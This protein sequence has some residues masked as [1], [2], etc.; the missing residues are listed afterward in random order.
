MSRPTNHEAITQTHAKLSTLT[1]LLTA[2]SIT[3]PT[4]AEHRELT[5]AEIL[6][7]IRHAVGYEK[8]VCYEQGILMAG[9]GEQIGLAG[10]VSLRI[11]PDGRFLFTFKGRVDMRAAFD[12][13]S[14]WIIDYRGLLRPLELEEIELAQAEA[15]LVSGYWLNKSAPFTISRAPARD[16]EHEVALLLERS[17]G[18]LS[19]YAHI[20]RKTWLPVSMDRHSWMGPERWEFGDFREFAGFRL[21]TRVTYTGDIGNFRRFEF[22]SI[23]EAP[24]A[25]TAPYAPP[26]LPCRARID[27]DGPADIEVQRSPDGLLMV[28]PLINGTDVGW[29]IFDTCGSAL[30]ITPKAAD[31]LGMAAFGKG[32]GVG[33]IGPVKVRLRPGKSF[34][35][36]PVTIDEPVFVELAMG[37]LNAGPSGPIAGICGYDLL[38][39]VVA[40]I[41]VAAPRIALYDPDKYELPAGQWQQ[42]VNQF[43]NLQVQATFEGNHQALFRIDTGSPYTLIMHTP[44]VKSLQLLDNRKTRLVQ[45]TSAPGSDAIYLG[46][47]DWFELAGHRFDE[48][49]VM[50]A[51]MKTNAMATPYVAGTIGQPFM[52]PFLVVVNYAAQQIAFIPHSDLPNR[53]AAAGD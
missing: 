53:H 1:L 43:G 42:S 12:G 37:F 14:G 28:R 20:D 51:V 45:G 49:K 15:W 39:H 22:D 9:R 27:P 46:K 2:L 3:P 30:S 41:E 29:F 38:A 33:G 48:P 13:Q 7:N 10:D 23:T 25:G 16:D 47:L 52:K 5:A 32:A 26:K 36:G 6:A 50:F 34:K 40:E 31:R 44:A 8:L 35:L 4:A 19:V 18:Q 24:G 17:D 21:P 11:A